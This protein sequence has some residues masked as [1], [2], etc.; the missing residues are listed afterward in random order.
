MSAT[1]RNDSLP[2]QTPLTRDNPLVD[3]SFHPNDADD[4]SDADLPTTE[5]DA[6]GWRAL[7]PS[8]P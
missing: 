7:S 5:H 8:K 2:I 4:E 3:L 1:A 6:E